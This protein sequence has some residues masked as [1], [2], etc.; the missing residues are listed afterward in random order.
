MNKKVILIFIGYI[1]I[2]VSSCLTNCD[3][4]ELS[5]IWTG[6]E[7]QNSLL[8]SEN[9]NSIYKPTTDSIFITRD[10][11]IFVNFK[12]QVNEKKNIVSGFD[13]FQ[14]A[15]A[16]CLEEEYVTGNNIERIEVYTLMDFDETHLR[17]SNIMDYIYTTSYN[18]MGDFI[19]YKPFDNSELRNISS[20]FYE[21]VDLVS[22]SSLIVITKKPTLD[23][24]QRFKINV[25][26]HDNPQFTDTTGFIRMR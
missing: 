2:G 15:S 6:I 18:N 3:T 22:F 21:K 12:S 4:K 17:N 14:K 20:S 10:L 13:F 8:V 16:K 9:G 5:F 7:L 24:L 23:S 11:G 26:L 1:V 19:G 25:Q